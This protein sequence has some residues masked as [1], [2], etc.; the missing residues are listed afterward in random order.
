[1]ATKDMPQ[2]RA[3]LVFLVWLELMQ[4][5]LRRDQQQVRPQ[6]TAS[7]TSPSRLNLGIS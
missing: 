2:G 1:M 7:R 6:E 5:D 3:R 4:A